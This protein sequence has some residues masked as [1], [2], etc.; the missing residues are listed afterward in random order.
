[1]NFLV[2]TGGFSWYSDQSKLRMTKDLYTELGEGKMKVQA[3]HGVH[4]ASYS[5][6]I[7][8]KLQAVSQPAH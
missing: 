7:V 1:M 3:S 4:P 8:G 6:P 2:V 5:V